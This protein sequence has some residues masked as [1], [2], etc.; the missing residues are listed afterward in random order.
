M[1]EL[2]HYVTKDLRKL[3]FQLLFKAFHVNTIKFLT[4]GKHLFQQ[5]KHNLRNPF[6]DLKAAH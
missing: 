2:L 5:W 1:Q 4:I 3:V 6:P